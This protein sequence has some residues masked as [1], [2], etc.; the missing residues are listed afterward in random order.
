MTTIER[1]R[2]VVTEA[3]MRSAIAELVALKGG[4]LFFVRDSRQAPEMT[5]FPDLVIL[6]PPRVLFVELKSHRRAT[7]A[8]QAE[9]IAMLEGCGDVDAIVVRPVPR[10]GEMAYA[11]FIAFLVEVA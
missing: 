3:A 10:A 4:R 9:V 1:Y 7:T 11:D 2:R 8:G 6:L 5:D